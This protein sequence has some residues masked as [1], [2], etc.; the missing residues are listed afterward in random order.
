MTKDIC[1]REAYKDKDGN[2]KV[3]WNKLGVLIEAANGKQYVKLYSIPGVLLNVFEPKPRE[4]ATQ[5]E[6]GW[7]E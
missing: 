7:A 3:S 5:A 6:E 1:I 2:E 4:Q